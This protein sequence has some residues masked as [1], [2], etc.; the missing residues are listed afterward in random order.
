[1]HLLFSGLEDSEEVKIPCKIFWSCP[2]ETF[3]Y[4]SPSFKSGKKNV[5][6][7][8]KFYETYAKTTIYFCT[9]HYVYLIIICFLYS[10]IPPPSKDTPNSDLTWDASRDSTSTSPNFAAAGASRSQDETE[11]ANMLS[12]CQVSFWMSKWIHMFIYLYYLV[13]IR[14]TSFV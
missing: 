4:S 12:E 8:V 13:V 10:I 2:R 1:M 11:A 5:P 9:M 3:R 14:I 7:G 6:K